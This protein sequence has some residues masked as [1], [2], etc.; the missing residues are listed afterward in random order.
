MGKIKKD[1]KMTIRVTKSIRDKLEII[2]N[3]EEKAYGEVIAEAISFYYENNKR[4][5]K[6]T[7]LSE[8]KTE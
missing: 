7:E 3:Q 8:K 6:E 2:A 5:K 1:I 4:S